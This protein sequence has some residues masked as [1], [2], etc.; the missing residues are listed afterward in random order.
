MY[1]YDRQRDAWPYLLQ[2]SAIAA[3]NGEV[4]YRIGR[5]DTPGDRL[6]TFLIGLASTNCTHPSCR[7]A[8]LGAAAVDWAYLM[9][10]DEGPDEFHGETMGLS[11]AP[12]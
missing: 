8:N 11:L 6:Q 1:V 4:N 2:V 5:M 3:R 12:E 9:Q 7:L 10:I